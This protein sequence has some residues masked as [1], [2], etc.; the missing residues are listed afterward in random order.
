MGNC[1]NRENVVYMMRFNGA[2]RHIRPLGVVWSLSDCDP[3]N[4][5]DFFQRSRAISV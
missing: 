5:F 4:I 1:F 2:L 3:T